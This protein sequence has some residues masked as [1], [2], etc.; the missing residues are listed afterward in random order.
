[1]QVLDQEFQAFSKYMPSYY[2]DKYGFKTLFQ[3]WFVSFV[4]LLVLV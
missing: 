3:C 1:M 2:G 4:V